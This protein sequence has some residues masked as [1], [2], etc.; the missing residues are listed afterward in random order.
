MDSMIIHHV[1]VI[2]RYRDPCIG[3][4]HLHSPGTCG[5]VFP[6]RPPTVFMQQPQAGIPEIKGNIKVL[7][8][9]A[10]GTPAPVYRW[11]K[12]EEFLTETNIT[13]RSL[14]IQDIKGSD[15]G[16]YQC[17]ASNNYGALLSSRVRVHVA[18]KYNTYNPCFIWFV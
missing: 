1:Y 16:E 17:I 15:A 12:D 7:L 4:F 9:H 10:S 8:C 14:K 18:C 5:C 11:V 3:P 6:G 2:R 13:E